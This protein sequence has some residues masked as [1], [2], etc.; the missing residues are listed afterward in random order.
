MG[1]YRWGARASD[2][3]SGVRAVDGTATATWQPSRS[4]VGGWSEKS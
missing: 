1:F 3:G 2:D 4:W